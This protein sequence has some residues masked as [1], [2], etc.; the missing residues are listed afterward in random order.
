MSMVGS[1]HNGQRGAE[2]G[3]SGSGTRVWCVLALLPMVLCARGRA[4]AVDPAAER[5]PRAA[6]PPVATDARLAGD[7]SRTRLIIDV[8]HNLGLTAFTLADP[9][10]VVIDLPQVA[11]QFPAKT[12]EAGPGLI[13]A[14]RLG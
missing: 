9:Y 6:T 4:A 10:R 5:P 7:E 8:S 2:G 12:G 1:R 14:V 3:P 11:F 13:K